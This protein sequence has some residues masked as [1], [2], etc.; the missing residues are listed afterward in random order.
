MPVSSR[1]VVWESLAPGLVLALYLL[2]G[3][4]A[5]GLRALR[6]GAYRDADTAARGQTALLGMGLRQY[7]S[8]LMRP[9][10]DRLVGWSIP[11]SALTSV[12]VLLS[13]MAAL[14]LAA[15]RFGLGGWL[16][17]LGGA[18]D[19]LDGRV[20]RRSGSASRA[21]AALDSIVDRYVESSVLLGLMWHYRQGWV[22]VPAALALIGSLLVPYVRA[23]G[24]GL[25]VT[26]P[27]V[28]VMQ[29]PERVALLGAGLVV[30]PLIEPLWPTPA[31]MMSHG[32]VVI[33]LCVLAV[34]TQLTAL[35]R[36]HHLLR[37]LGGERWAAPFRRAGVGRSV[38]TAVA[39]TCVD[40][41]V[42]S[43][44]VELL[45]TAPVRATLAGACVG[46]LCNFSLN[47]LWAFRSVGPWAA[48]G[49][50]YGFVS[51][52]SAL[53][54][55]MGVGALLVLPGLDYRLAWALSR[56]TVFLFWNYPLQRNY[57]FAPAEQGHR[58]PELFSGGPGRVS[59]SHHAR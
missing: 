52:S 13:C 4:A 28:G 33:V 56:G 34:S 47:R 49:A 39:A 21:G 24:E 27:N 35:Q 17:L 16:Y 14:E 3:A 44:L 15:G 40:F 46:A 18:C 11:A 54:N 8:W 6:R 31:K 10:I 48:Q 26:F 29:R 58:A 30:S 19:F 45:G 22:L 57:V 20:A 42:V 43:A 36:L 51:G 25:G 53:L 2:L 38:L 7:F 55:A 1:V 32:T 59:R 5:Y 41:L 50:R 12:S 37:Q 9:L 23:R